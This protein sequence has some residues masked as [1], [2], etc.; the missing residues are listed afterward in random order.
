MAL[1]AGAR[2]HP[3]LEGKLGGR[4]EIERKDMMSEGC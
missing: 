1:A 4:S 3:V 2:E